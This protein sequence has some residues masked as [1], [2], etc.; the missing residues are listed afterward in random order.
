MKTKRKSKAKVYTA[1]QI[2]VLL[3]HEFVRGCQKGLDDHQRMENFQHARELHARRLEVMQVSC[4]L[5]RKAGDTIANIGE[6]LKQA[7]TNK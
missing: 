4:D 2:E 5:V 1:K 6:V 7:L 3:K